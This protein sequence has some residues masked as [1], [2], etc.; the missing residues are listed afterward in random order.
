[1]LNGFTS[2]AITKDLTEDIKRSL[3]D[4]AKKTVC[5]GI[6]EEENVINDDI[7]NAELLYIHTHGVRDV[8]MRKAMQHDLDSGTPYSKAHELYVHENGS[9]LW[10]SPPRP[11]LEPSIDANKEIIAEQMKQVAVA[12]LDGNNPSTELEKV[13]M[14][15]QNV[16]RDW[17]TNPENKWPAN[18]PETVKRKGSDMPLIDTGE[19]RKSITYVI[20]EGE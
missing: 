20:K 15:G 7:A 12:A 2:V 11:V 16:A 1:M 18:S 3:E 6:P 5:V 8:T 14:L 17:F 19:L 4:L 9:P 13:G 10:H